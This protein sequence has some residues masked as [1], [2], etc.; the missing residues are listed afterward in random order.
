MTTLD[1]QMAPASHDAS[2]IPNRVRELSGLEAEH[3][4]EIEEQVRLKSAESLI[5]VVWDYL[6]RRNMH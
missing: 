3:W 1:G 5:R 2:T 6:D 4:L